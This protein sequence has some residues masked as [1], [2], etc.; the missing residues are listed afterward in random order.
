MQFSPKELKKIY[1]KVRF[2]RT[3]EEM[4]M[5]VYIIMFTNLKMVD[6]LGWF[7]N[8][9][10]K[11]RKCLKNLHILEDYEWCKRLFTKKHQTYLINWKKACKIWLGKKNITFEDFR[12]SC[13]E[14]KT[15][16]F[17][18]IEF[19]EILFVHN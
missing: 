2:R 5:L 4:S 9:I 3:T 12:Q 18:R 10:G 15:K 17:M 1:D 13:K 8:D 7:N 14:A 16:G 6:L 19:D 11:R